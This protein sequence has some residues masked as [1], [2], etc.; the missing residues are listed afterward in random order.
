MRHHFIYGKYSYEYNLKLTDRR[1]FS[2]EV[3]PNLTI[4]VSSPCDASSS[5]IEAFLV[6]KWAWL[7]KQ[8]SELRRY[9]KSNRQKQYVAGEAFY[10]LGRQYMLE[11]EQAHYDGVKFERNRIKLYTAS[12]LRDSQR[13]KQLLDNWY[14]WR[15]QI[16]FKQ[17]FNSTL[18]LFTDIE[19]PQLLIK[20][21]EKRW[22]SYKKN[23]AV[24]L[25]PKLIH[26]SREAI[27]YVC[28]HELCHINNRNHDE[29]FYRLMDKLM[30][31]WRS[32][33]DVLEVKF[34]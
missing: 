28:I 15:R 17:E 27:R 19:K 7:E 9:S 22:G 31:N 26:A 32:V 8:L 16:V 14:A 4:V 12:D 21:M 1:S 5:D 3:Q 34:G 13:N 20:P 11:V 33:K 18:K 23:S 24:V 2:L 6:R 30:P 10:Y 29:N 25:N